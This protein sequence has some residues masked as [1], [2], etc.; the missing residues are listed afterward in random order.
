MPSNHELWSERSNNVWE[1]REDQKG[2]IARSIFYFYT[3]YPETVGD[4]S[5]CGD[6][7]TLYQWHLDDPVDTAEQDRNDKIE[8]QQGN[9]NPY[10]DYPDLVW[11]VVFKR[12]PSTPTAPSMENR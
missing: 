3:M 4:I 9:R 6:P 12:L 10:V 2:T 5:Q 11:D 8:S 1:P 7:E